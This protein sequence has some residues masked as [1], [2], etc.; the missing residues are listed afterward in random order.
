MHDNP[1]DDVLA[2]DRVRTG[3][4][5]NVGH[6]PQRGQPDGLVPWGDVE[7]IKATPTSNQGGAFV[8]APVTPVV[9]ES[10]RVAP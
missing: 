5:N 1:A 2:I 4:G 10:I 9:I 3:C 8:N 6:G 7:K